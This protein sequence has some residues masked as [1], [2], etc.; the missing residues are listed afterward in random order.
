MNGLSRVLGS[1]LAANSTLVFDEDE[2]RY[3]LEVFLGGLWQIVLLILAGWWLGILQELLAVMFSAALPRRY[4]GGAHC[5]AY[6]RCTLTGLITFPALVYLCRYIYPQYFI[7]AYIIISIFIILTVLFLA[8]Q[9]TTVKPINDYRQRQRLKRKALVVVGFLLITAVILFRI[10]YQ[11]AVGIL[12]G[13]GWQAFTM[14]RCGT[15]YMR[16]FDA[17]LGNWRVKRTGKEVS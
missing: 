9:D 6:Y 13:L 12:M 11:L 3:G 2:I 1:L 14:T 10:D 5:S 4:A 7:A 16:F 8:P 17:L 15:F